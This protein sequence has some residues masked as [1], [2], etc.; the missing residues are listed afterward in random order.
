MLKT[1]KF[2]TFQFNVS[3]LFTFIW[4]IDKTLSGANSLSQSEPHN[5]GVLHIPQSSNITESSP[6][7]CLVSYPGH[8]LGNS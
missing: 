4:T 1:V 2:Q 5:E 6:S 3:T 8:L 7:D